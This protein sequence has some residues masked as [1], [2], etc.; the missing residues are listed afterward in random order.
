MSNLPKI[1]A[2]MK[3]AIASILEVVLKIVLFDKSIKSVE[4]CT[5]FLFL[6]GKTS[7]MRSNKPIFSFNQFIFSFLTDIFSFF[8]LLL[9]LKT[10]ENFHCILDII[11]IKRIKT[12]GISGC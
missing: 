11:G 8:N 5:D 6:T 2:R 9:K 1:N 3:H 12:L 10:S 7:K 4:I